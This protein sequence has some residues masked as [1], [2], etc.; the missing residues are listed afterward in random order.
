MANRLLIP[1]IA[2]TI[3][4]SGMAFPFQSAFA[5][6]PEAPTNLRDSG[7]PGATNIPLLWSAPG[8]G[9]TPDGYRID[10]AT[11]ISFQNFGSFSTLVADTGS[12][13]VSYNV[14]GLIEGE[15]YRFRVYSLH[16]ADVSVGYAEA[17]RGTK[18]D[19]AQDFSGGHQNFN[20]G[21]HHAEGTQFAEGQ[22]F[23]GGTQ[24]FAANQVL[25][26]ELLLLLVR[27]FLQEL[28]LLV[29]DQTLNKAQ[30]LPK[31]K[32]S[33]ELR[34]LMVKWNSKKELNLQNTKLLV[35]P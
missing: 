25:V 21:Q 4:S 12:D 26:L 23:T 31:V 28:K 16:G 34:T 8:S 11:E 6:V 3:L 19:S 20:E 10:Y 18:Y 7:A 22:S 9:Q 13:A 17:D 14:T 15:F 24:N 1:F 27:T 35:I 2:F 32:L 33:L 30:H 29:L 5:V